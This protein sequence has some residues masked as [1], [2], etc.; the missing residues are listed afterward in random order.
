M[1]PAFFQI[2]PVKDIP[3]AAE[4]MV[5]PALGERFFGFGFG[6]GV[7]VDLSLAE[8]YHV[9]A[10]ARW[11]QLGGEGRSADYSTTYSVGGPAVLLTLS[12]Y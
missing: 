1:I 5:G 8:S 7:S 10:A 6:A 11:L 4:A 9:G 2:H 12:Y 3:V